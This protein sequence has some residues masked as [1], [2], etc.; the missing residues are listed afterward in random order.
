MECPCMTFLL[1]DYICPFYE[2]LETYFLGRV[3]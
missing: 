2:T 3:I 1:L